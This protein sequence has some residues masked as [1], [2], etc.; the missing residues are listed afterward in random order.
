MEKHQLSKSTFIRGVQ[1][2][3]S[4]Y[5]Y[6]N[7]YFLRDKLSPEQMAKF[8]RGTDVGVFAQNLFPGGIDCKPKSPS[9]Y[10]KSVEK[11]ATVISEGSHDVIYEAAFQYDR[12][13]ILLDILAK[14]NGKWNAYEIKSSLKISETY[15]MDAALQY[16]VLTSSGIDVDRFFLVHINPDYLQDDELKLQELF[17]FSDVTDE[18]RSRQDFVKEQIEKSKETIALKKSPSIDIGPHCH[19][20]YPCDFI[21]HCWKHLPEKSVFG[22]RSFSREEQFELYRQNRMEVDLLDPASFSDPKKKTEL[23]CIQVKKDF[24]DAE[25]FGE[26]SSS[27]KPPLLFAGLLAHRVAVPQWKGYKPFDLIPVSVSMVGEDDSLGK[28]Y[29]NADKEADPDPEFIRF[30]KGH[31]GS[32]GNILTYDAVHFSVLLQR[33][34]ER[35]PDEQKFIN[36]LTGRI[37]DLKKVTDDFIYFHPGIAPDQTIYDLGTVLDIRMDEPPPFQSRILAVNEYLKTENNPGASGLFVRYTYLQARLVKGFLQFLEM[38]V[39]NT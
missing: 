3:K 14:Q 12:V 2:L 10:R 30:L 22:L 21:G 4:L 27:M 8:K 28:N 38:K 36:S 37:I 9:Q 34:G 11:T 23:E 31:A 6:K 32:D 29:Y 19:D 5:L 33:I 39:K 25:G 13:L 18:A 7:R 16:Y 1:C 15:L 24:F 17:V 35:N 26:V 20:P